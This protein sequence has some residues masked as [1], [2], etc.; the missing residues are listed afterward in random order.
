MYSAAINRPGLDNF[1]AA[2]ASTATK[3]FLCI[4]A[5]LGCS[6]QFRCGCSISAGPIPSKKLSICRGSLH[7]STLKK[8]PTQRQQLH[9]VWRC[10]PCCVSIIYLPVHVVIQTSPAPRYSYIA[11][12]TYNKLISLLSPLSRMRISLTGTHAISAAARVWL[13]AVPDVSH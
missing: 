13:Q 11:L 10:A 12:G 6:M 5:C 9:V 8:T 4:A 3:D 1:L 7:C 2:W